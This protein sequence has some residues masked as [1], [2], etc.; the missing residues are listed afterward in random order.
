MSEEHNLS[1]TKV[2]AMIWLAW[3]LFLYATNWIALS[4][5]WFIG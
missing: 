1:G 5:N 4:E 2:L 3:F